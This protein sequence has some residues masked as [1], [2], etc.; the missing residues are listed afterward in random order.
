MSLVGS[1]YPIIKVVTLFA[2]SMHK[3]CVLPSVCMDI[4]WVNTYVVNTH[5]GT[6][7]YFL[8]FNNTQ[9]VDG[10]S[11]ASPCGLCLV[12]NYNKVIIVNWTRLVHGSWSDFFRN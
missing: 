9:K 1:N 2:S 5:H 11:I 7:F 6:S 3:I 4:N 10:F 12:S 8:K